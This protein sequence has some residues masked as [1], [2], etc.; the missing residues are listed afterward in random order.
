MKRVK[1]GEKWK[2]YRWEKGERV[3]EGEIWEQRGTYR[4]G[5][6]VGNG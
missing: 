6:K 2:C 4:G 5:K 1:G 3:K